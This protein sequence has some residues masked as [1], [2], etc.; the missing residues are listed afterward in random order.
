[1]VFDA[2]QSYP[3]LVRDGSIDE[4]LERTDDL[5]I[6]PYKRALRCER[7]FK[8]YN[9]SWDYLIDTFMVPQKKD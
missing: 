1:M 9:A 7:E 4:W 2:A 8:R 3:N 5:N 6:L